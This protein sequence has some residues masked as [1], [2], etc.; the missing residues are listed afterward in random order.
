VPAVPSEEPLSRQA[1]A[2]LEALDRGAAPVAS[3]AEGWDVVRVLEAAGRSL[4]QG[5]TPAA[6]APREERGAGGRTPGGG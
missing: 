6:V 4:R 5:G 2:F 1:R 3:G